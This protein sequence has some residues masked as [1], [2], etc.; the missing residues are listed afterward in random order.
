MV[1]REKALARLMKDAYKGGGYT[2]AVRKNGK[3]GHHH[4]LLG[5]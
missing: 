1:I 3:N 4:K 2:V 5:C